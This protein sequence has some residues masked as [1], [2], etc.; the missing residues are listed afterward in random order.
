MRAYNERHPLGAW[1]GQIGA[2][3]RYS[4]VLQNLLAFVCGCLFTDVITTAFSSL[5]AGPTPPVFVANVCITLGFTLGASL[6]LAASKDHTISAD[7][8]DVEAFFLVNSAAFFVGWMWLV[9][10]R[11]LVTM[12]GLA[13]RWLLSP[14]GVTGANDDAVQFVAVLIA[15][16][17]CTAGAWWL[18]LTMQARLGSASRGPTAV[19]QRE[20][21]EMR[22]ERRLLKEAQ[23][24]MQHE[25]LESP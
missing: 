4:D 14:F 15:A 16:P 24:N 5:N 13:F 10:A 12:V 2:A 9:V 22:H 23:A 11:D 1:A 7:R 25:R 21:E 19:A 18:Q 6:Y 20:K 8:E 17:A 3:I